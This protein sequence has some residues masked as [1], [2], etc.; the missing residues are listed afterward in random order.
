MKTGSPSDRSAVAPCSSWRR[1][2]RSILISLLLT[3]GAGRAGRAQRACGV[4]RWRVKVALD[5]TVAA[6]DTVALEASVP[7]LGHLP[8]PSGELPHAARAAPHEL[9]VFHV[10]AVLGERRRES[11]GD[12]HLVLYDPENPGASMIAEIPDSACALGSP[13]AHAFAVARRRSGSIPTGTTI[14][15]TGIGF[16]D[17]SHGQYGDAPNS[18]ELHPVLAIGRSAAS[19]GASRPTSRPGAD[20]GTATERDAAQSRQKPDSTRKVWVNTASNVYHCPGSRW[21]GT[22]K[23][24]TYMTEAEAHAAGAR[25]AYGR[26]CGD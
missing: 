21:Y 13:W 15:V 24:G 26:S 8:R 16:F 3:L 7:Q 25:P 19:L 23:H 9:R 11:D 17:Y 12:I 18:F 20:T 14:S 6:V 22:T 10:L 4:E 1:R 2:G 5:S